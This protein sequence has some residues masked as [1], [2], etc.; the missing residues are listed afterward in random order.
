MRRLTTAALLIAAATVAAETFGQV[1]GFTS[2]DCS[3]EITY[4]YSSVA[5]ACASYDV[6]AYRVPSA[7]IYECTVCASDPGGPGGGGIGTGGG[8]VT[9][10]PLPCVVAKQDHLR[11]IL[12]TGTST[13]IRR[14]R[15]PWG[16]T[17]YGG[18]RGT[19]SCSELCNGQWRLHG[20]L[21]LKP[22]ADIQ[23]VANVGL[24]GNCG[25]GA[26]RTYDKIANTVAH[27]D[28]HAHAYVAKINEFRAKIYGDW[29][30]KAQCDQ[31]GSKVLTDFNSEYE[32]LQGTH[33]NH[34]GTHTGWAKS[35]R[36]C[37]SPYTRLTRTVEIWC[38]QR[39]DGRARD[40]PNGNTY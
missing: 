17:N 24:A 3:D 22:G 36:Y 1:M 15:G 29:P 9:P 26:E 14:N 21:D 6:N 39:Y 37:P 10:P 40:C 34:D 32:A 35:A 38:G 27:E 2:F 13:M 12:P 33:S 4:E 31:H 5:D 25:L 11:D 7:G 30:T 19:T 16:F 28:V 20:T 23:I 8:G 18:V